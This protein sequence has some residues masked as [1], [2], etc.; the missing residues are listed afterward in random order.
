MQETIIQNGMH[1]PALAYG[2][3]ALAGFSAG[4][5]DAI[6]GGGGLISLPALLAAGLP[7]HLALGTNKLQAGLG[8]SVAAANYARRGLLAGREVPLGAA[9]TAVGA[10][11]GAAFVSHLPSAWLARVVPWLLVAIFIHVARARRFGAAAGRAR[12]GATG[13]SIG[14]G[15]ILGFY[16]GFFGPGTGSFWTLGFVALRGFALPQATAHTKVMNLTSN[17]VA[18]AWFAREGDV[19]WRL[20]LGIAAAN[21][22]GA[23]AGSSLAIEKGA[24]LIR[25]VFLLAVAATLAHLA[26]RSL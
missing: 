3:L 9:C 16:D 13:F 14:G 22:A 20:G 8:T 2:A 5:V 10:L 1:L 11:A 26:W 23:A 19:A 24:R 15:L 17:A 25:A 6:A 4:F 12:V 7:P 18:L 21:I